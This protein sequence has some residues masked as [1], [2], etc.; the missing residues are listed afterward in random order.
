MHHGGRVRL[1]AI[2]SAAILIVVLLAV[3]ASSVSPLRVTC[4]TGMDVPEC[5]GTVTASLSR[6]LAPV[7][8][9]IVAAH[10]EPGPAAATD[11]HGHRAT[12]TF[13]L[14]GVPGTTSVRLFY[15]MGGHWGAVP[16]RTAVELA[17]WALVAAAAVVGIAGIAALALR[18]RHPQ[19][20]RQTAS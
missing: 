3:A 14:L 15:D 19:R 16:D 5:Q 6:G 11:A 7:H 12:V 10:V 4:A 17:A 1:A 2:A 8:P 18:R 20:R 13:D 9:L